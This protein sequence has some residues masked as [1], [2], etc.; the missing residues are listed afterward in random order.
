MLLGIST[1]SRVTSSPPNVVPAIPAA[2]KYNGHW[3]REASLLTNE[4]V[5]RADAALVVQH[6]LLNGALPPLVSLGGQLP[7]LVTMFI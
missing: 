5:Q 2:N 1:Y 6:D 3:T 4:A 7:L